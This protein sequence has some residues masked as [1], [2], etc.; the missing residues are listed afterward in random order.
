MDR[1]TDGQVGGRLDKQV[2][3]GWIDRLGMDG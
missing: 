1:R 2:R 3:G